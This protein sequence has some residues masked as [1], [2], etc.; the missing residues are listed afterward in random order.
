M[1]APVSDK[2]EQMNRLNRWLQRIGGASTW[3]D[4]CLIEDQKHVSMKSTTCSRYSMMQN[5]IHDGGTTC[6]AA[7][8]ADSALWNRVSPM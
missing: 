1:V 7:T 5:A 4:L 2:V 3:E 8:M 6:C